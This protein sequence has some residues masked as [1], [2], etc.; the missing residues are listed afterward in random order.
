M[1]LALCNAQ[2]EL[3]PLEEGLHALGSGMPVREY[4]HKI[5]KGKGKDAIHDRVKAAQIFDLC[6]H[7]PTEQL[8][9]QWRALSELHAAPRWLWRALVSRL[10]SEGWTVETAR[11][12]AQKMKDVAEPPAWVDREAI[13]RDLIDRELQRGAGNSRIAEQPRNEDGTVGCRT[14]YNVHNSASDERPSGNT[15]DA[16]L[17]R[18]RKAAEFSDR[19]GNC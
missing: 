14:V 7:M 13:A 9:K 16:G 11:R 19:C 17:R 4:A 6:R 10:V 2:G 5:G 8:Q 12:E 15:I 3:H 18:L 1:A